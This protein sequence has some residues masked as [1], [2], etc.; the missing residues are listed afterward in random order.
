MKKS[1]ENS[2]ST[3]WPYSSL[4]MFGYFGYNTPGG[5]QLFYRTMVAMLLF[6]IGIFGIVLTETT[7]VNYLFA[8]LIP[9]S[10]SIFIWSYIKY[11]SVLDD[12][13][14]LIQLKA[15]A[16]TYGAAMFIGFTMYALMMVTNLQ[17]SPIWLILA[18]PVRGVV[19]GLVARRYE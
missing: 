11:L 19:L 18:E 3:V 5:K 1:K 14:K 2:E 15:F 16:F 17:I 4:I 7:L 12:L 13:S 10:V 8:S 6:I 9:I